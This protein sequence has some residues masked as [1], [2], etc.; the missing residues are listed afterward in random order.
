MS[1]LASNCAMLDIVIAHED[2]ELAWQSL[3]WSCMSETRQD[4]VQEIALYLV[5]IN[6][7]GACW[8]NVSVW[9][10][11]CGARSAIQQSN[12]EMK[13]SFWTMALSI[14]LNKLQFGEWRVLTKRCCFF[15]NSHFHNSSTE[16]VSDFEI[17]FCI[18]KSES[19]CGIDSGWPSA[20]RSTEDLHFL[21]LVCG[22]YGSL[23]V[24]SCNTSEETVFC[25][26]LI[27]SRSNPNQTD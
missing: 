26:H 24:F 20:L 21:Q 22:G 10:W 7:L 14:Y 19:C 8:M 4:L 17:W 25:K 2:S 18:W 1:G 15:H 12:K 6:R 11:A 13:V 3:H 27:P 9:K 23:K 5:W 16:C